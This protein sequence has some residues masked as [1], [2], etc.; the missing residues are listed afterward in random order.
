LVQTNDSRV[1]VESV[2]TE[3]VGLATAEVGMESE[4]VVPTTGVA[5]AADREGRRP[6]MTVK[7]GTRDFAGEREALSNG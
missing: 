6:P 3:G 5:L 2:T 7:N 1:P 4:E